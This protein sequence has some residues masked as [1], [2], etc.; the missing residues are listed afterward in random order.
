MSFFLGVHLTQGTLKGCH[1]LTVGYKTFLNFSFQVELFSLK[2]IKFE[3]SESLVLV[4][5]IK[6]SPV[7]GTEVRSHR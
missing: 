5:V 4:E 1:V 7:M 3:Q 6:S 2:V